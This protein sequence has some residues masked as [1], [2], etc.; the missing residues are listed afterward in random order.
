MA[1]RQTAKEAALQV[2]FED[3]DNLLERSEKLPVAI[4]EAAASAASSIQRAGKEACDSITT[5]SKKSIEA[6]KKERESLI[7]SIK[8]SAQRVEVATKLTKKAGN[9][10]ALYAILLGGIAGLIMGVIGGVLAYFL[11]P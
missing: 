8:E 7:A 4:E 5:S 9:K 3:M 6:D 10:I 2:L 1:I 11:F